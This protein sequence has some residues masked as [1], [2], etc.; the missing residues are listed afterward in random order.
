MDIYTSIVIS[1]VTGLISGFV[2]S[3]LTWA[4]LFH[5]LSPKIDFSEKILKN[6]T[7]IAGSGFIYRVKFQNSRKRTA[8]NAHLKASI[9]FPDLFIKGTDNLFNLPLSSPFM[10]EIISC[11]KPG[12]NR[13][14]IFFKLEDDK[15]TK[16]FCKDVFPEHIK[17]MAMRKKLILEDLFRITNGSHIRISIHCFDSIS[18]ASKL[19]RSKN[20]YINDIILGEDFNNSLEIIPKNN[21]EK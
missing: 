20:Y 8:I 14:T 7:K 1:I 15:F 12:R 13:K 17:M 19:F 2:A 6:E 16:I 3:F 9:V 10:S 21:L 18:G 5:V 11:Y 4:L